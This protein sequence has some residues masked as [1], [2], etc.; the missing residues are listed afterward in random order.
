MSHAAMHAVESRRQMLEYFE[1]NGGILFMV[2]LYSQY[3]MTKPL[4]SIASHFPLHASRLT[5]EETQRQSAAVAVEIAKQ[6]R[7]ADSYWVQRNMVDLVNASFEAMP[8]HPMTQETFPVPFGW[9]HLEQVVR[10][11]D[12]DWD[13]EGSTDNVDK[14]PAPHLMFHAISWRRATEV[15]DQGRYR[16]GYEVWLYTDRDAVEREVRRGLP[17]R[18]MTPMYLRDLPPYVPVLQFF[19]PDG[20]TM[21]DATETY[22][23]A[24][25]A[26]WVHAC[27]V[28]MVMPIAVPARMMPDRNLSK[29]FARLELPVNRLTVVTMRSPRMRP[30]DDEMEHEGRE[31][32]HRWLVR[33]FWRNQFYPSTGEHK[34]IYINPFIKGPADKPVVFKEHV[35]AWIR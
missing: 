17:T 1:G 16:P 8:S 19:W 23:S 21:P 30:N 18:R 25:A 4:P 11:E 35:N 32:S 22:L 29:R 27:M 5:A 13:V 3:A 28:L 34:V 10:L 31:Y 26:T 33:G 2:S 15:N 24:M 6:Y 7:L 14:A 12:P 9:M 20:E